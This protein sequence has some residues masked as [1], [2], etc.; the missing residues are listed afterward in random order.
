MKFYLFNL[1]RDSIF[2]RPACSKHAVAVLPNAVAALPTSEDNFILLW[3]GDITPEKSI[4]R[5]KTES[6]YIVK[7]KKSSFQW[8]NVSMSEG[9]PWRIYRDQVASWLYCDYWLSANEG[10]LQVSRKRTDILVLPK[11][12][13]E[14]FLSDIQD[15]TPLY[16]LCL[17][18]KSPSYMT[19]YK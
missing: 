10:I 14:S 1:T 8:D 9:C 11:R 7:L 15:A 17:S 5:L 3:S 19:L 16:S 2:V 13:T 18:G 6:Q 4:F 12:P